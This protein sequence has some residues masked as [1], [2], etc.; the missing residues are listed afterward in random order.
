MVVGVNMTDESKEAKPEV[1]AEQ[2]EVEKGSEEVQNE[3]RVAKLV[4][5]TN[6]AADRIEKQNE[7]LEQNLN[8]QEKLQADAALAGTADAGSQQ[9][10]E[11]EKAVEQARKLIEGSGFEERLFGKKKE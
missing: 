3:E 10:S 11:E 2:K 7:R 1:Q 8:R 5:D 9:L 4:D 6:A